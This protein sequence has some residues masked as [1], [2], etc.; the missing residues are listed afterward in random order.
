MSDALDPPASRGA[1]RWLVSLGIASAL[2]LVVYA[3]TRGKAPTPTEASCPSAEPF[4]WEADPAWLQGWMRAA[5][6]SRGVV[7]RDLQAWAQ[8]WGAARTEACALEADVRQATLTCLDRQ[9]ARARALADVL[10]ELPEQA[11]PTAWAAGMGLPPTED[12]G[13]ARATP[14][15]RDA[16]AQTTLDRAN[17][18]LAAGDVDAASALVR[19]LDLGE[20]DP[21]RAQAQWLEGHGQPPALAY[22]TW[23]RALGDAIAGDDPALASTIALALAATTPLDEGLPVA[24]RWWA[25]ASAHAR[26]R[27]TNATRQ[28]ALLAT[29]ASMLAR[30]GRADD[31]LSVHEPALALLESSVGGTHPALVPGLRESAIAAA[32]VG[33]LDAAERLATRALELADDA[34]GARHPESLATLDAIASALKSGGTPE[35]ATAWLRM[36]NERRPED[37]RGPGLVELGEAY[38]QAGRYGDA[39]DTFDRALT[40]SLAHDASALTLRIALGRAAVAQARGD[41][42]TA[43]EHLENALKE[44]DLDARARETVRLRLVA[45]LLGAG[46]LD[47]ARG[48]ATLALEATK[49]ADDA[50]RGEALSVAADV[51]LRSGRPDEAIAFARRAV[52]RLVRAH[53]TDAPSVLLALTHLGTA[54][55]DEKRDDEASAAFARAFQ[56]ARTGPPEVEVAAALGWA[57]A[58]WRTGSKEEATELVREVHGRV[59]QAARPGAAADAAAWLAQHDLPLEPPSDG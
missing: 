21:L 17:G 25:L 2:G 1:T 41:A 22:A 20:D 19:S 24:Q 48:A 11:Q 39:A 55:L 7:E 56:I 13:G 43:A 49:D 32:S 29:Q 38:L 51:A 57:T 35:K 16:A 23:Q 10:V 12:C 3:S 18:L 14:P 9:A 8:R 4:R 52:A 40:W 44:E 59:A 15:P 5:S 46:R 45:V 58:L 30:H 27:P 28:H 53:G 31:A 37:A 26:R 47:D 50:A 36:A 6:G 33:K 34:L 42:D 54:C